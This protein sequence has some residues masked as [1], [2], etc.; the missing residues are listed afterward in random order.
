MV[1]TISNVDP[2]KYSY[3]ELLQ[4][5]G[6][7]SLPHVSAVI[8]FAI[9]LHCDIPSSNDRMIALSDL[10]VLKMFKIYNSREI[11][12][13]VTTMSAVLCHIV[14]VSETITVSSQSSEDEISISDSDDVYGLTFEDEAFVPLVGE[15]LRKSTFNTAVSPSVNVEV[16]GG[17]DLSNF[18]SND[19]VE[20]N[21][22][23]NDNNTDSNTDE[24][25]GQGQ[26]QGKSTSRGFQR[27]GETLLNLK[28]FPFVTYLWIRASL[29]M[30]LPAT[31]VEVKPEKF[32]EVKEG[33]PLFGCDLFDTEVVHKIA[34]VFLPGLGSACVDNTTGGIFKSPASVAVDIRKEMVDY[35]TQRSETFVA[36]SVILEGG[37]DAKVSDH[38]YD[39]ISDL[40]D[41]F[42]ISKRNFFSRVS[43]WLLSERREDRIDD[44]VQE[45][46]VNG[47]WL[48]DRR[49]AIAQTL[50]RNVDLKNTFHCNMKFN[51]VEELLEHVPQCSFRTLN[52]TSEGCNARFCAAHLGNHDSICPFKILPCEQKCSDRIMRRE[53]DRHCITV[54]PMKLVNCP[55]YPVGCQS[56]IPQCMIEQHRSENIHSHMLHVL[57]GIHKEASMEDLRARVEQLDES[58][59][60]GQLAEAR[61]V[62]SLTIKIKNL[63]AKL[64]P[65]IVNTKNKVSEE[66]IE[67]PVKKE[68]CTDS[69]TKG[70]ALTE[71]PSKK[72][73]STLS[74]TKREEC[75]DSLSK[76]EECAESPTKKEFT[77]S[78]AKEEEFTESPAK[79]DETNESPSKKVECM[80][81]PTEKEQYMESPAEREYTKSLTKTEECTQ[82]PPKK[83]VE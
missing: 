61:D 34:Q 20:Y 58:S 54:C 12:I 78:P 46:E 9:N 79:K 1:N 13:Y 69:P 71:S 60:P 28:V 14:D 24:G 57:Q 3:I 51:S 64:G 49:E 6:E 37:P 76:R 5:V 32:E 59:S 10:D 8:G 15:N 41:D 22:S 47:F 35:L 2:D 39:I 77:E 27:N 70:K 30:D 29:S 17:D 82:S 67:S 42:A 31:D 63:E 7:L 53:M 18:D 45:M 52:C 72:E 56:T 55:F 75:T 48:M 16:H 40:V 38:P 62:R 36:E 25:Q 11:N 81:S 74:P 33:G 19:D 68:E 50:L 43:G 66:C 4:D 44:F 80:E 23:S 26:G 65:L 83:E 73:E 21:P